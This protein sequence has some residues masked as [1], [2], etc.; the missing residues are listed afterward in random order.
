[1]KKNNPIFRTTFVLIALF[2]IFSFRAGA[3]CGWEHRV[4]AVIAEQNL[5]PSARKR[6]KNILGPQTS[7]AAVSTWADFVR[8]FRPATAP[9]HY[10]NYPLEMEEPDYDVMKTAE[11][12]IVFAIE[13]LI[14]LLK[15]PRIKGEKQEE[16]LKFL[17]HF[18][19][20]IHQP[21]HCGKGEDRGG[22]E[23]PVSWREKLTNLHSVWDCCLSGGGDGSPALWAT[24]LLSEVT[25]EERKRIMRGEPYD[26]MVES[27]RLAREF[28]YPRLFQCP[29][30]LGEQ[31]HELSGQYAS[32]AQPVVRRRLTE[33]GLRLAMILNDIFSE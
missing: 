21:L 22:N 33:A 19:G 8:K 14:T 18:V 7:L 2:F 4:I 17:I 6:V 28:C 11:E 10:I 13:T 16:A 20:D 23:V 15:D 24:Y 27:H 29:A 26:W 12:N 1:M 3:W 32:A 9:W 25:A 31:I 5:S 30:I